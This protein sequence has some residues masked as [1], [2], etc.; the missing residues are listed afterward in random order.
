MYKYIDENREHLHTF[1]DKPLIGTSTAMNVVAKNLTWWAAELAAVEALESGNHIPTIRAEYLTAC[2]SPDKK[3]AIDALQKKYPP[4]KA[5]RFAHFNVKNEKA[6][7][8]TDLHAE[9]ERFVNDQMSGVTDA[10]YEARIQPFIDWAKENVK[11][12]L[13]SE[14]HCYSEKMWV[15]GISDVGVELNDGEIAIIDF[16]SSKEAFVTHFFQIAGYD[17][18][19]TENGWFDKDGKQLGK[20]DKPITKHIVVPFGAQT[21]VPVVSEKVVINREAFEHA[22]GL[23]KIMQHLGAI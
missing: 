10:T 7:Q 15:G 6:K 11:I 13:W 23:Y 17:L 19:V 12:Y 1:Q 14:G 4:F 2:A 22:I 3:K 18:Q 16:K 20:L 5:A 9:L 8:G 21:V